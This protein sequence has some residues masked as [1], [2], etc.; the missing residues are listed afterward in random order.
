MANVSKINGYDLKDT[1]AREQ[2]LG[3]NNLVEEKYQANSSK[4][5]NVE[6][7][8][9]NADAETNARIDGLATLEDG[10]TTGDAELIDARTI[11]TINYDNLG[12]AIRTEFSNKGKDIET[13]IG[14]DSPVTSPALQDGYVKYT[15]YTIID[16][17][18][19]GAYQ[20]TG[21]IDIP[22]KT[23]KIYHNFRFQGSAG[24][25]FFDSNKEAISGGNTADEISVIP[26]NAR[27]IMFSDYEL[28]GNHTG[29]NYQM[30]ISF[31]SN[32][33]LKERL[34]NTNFNLGY[35][36]SGTDQVTP[37]LQDGFVDTRNDSIKNESFSNVYKR[38]DYIEIPLGT[39]KIQHNFNCIN[40]CGY[41]F[42]DSDYT[43]I[44]TGNTASLITSIPEDAKYVMFSDYDLS[45]Q[46]TGK[47]I[48]FICEPSLNSLQQQIN[49]IDNPGCD[50]TNLVTY[51][52]SHVA[53]G[54]WQPD[55][56]D[57]FDITNHTNL[58]VSSSTV[59][60]NTDSEVAPFV[61]SDRISAIETAN[62]DTIII[63]GGTN[64]VHLNTPLGTNAQLSLA[65]ASKDKS[66]F[67]GAYSYLIETL[68]TW[69][70][71]L[72]IILC[73]IPQG[74]Y[75]SGHSVSYKDI[76]DAVKEIANYY[77]LPVADIFGKC[78]INKTNLSTY[79]DDSIHYN[80]TGNKRVSKNIIATI[81]DCYI[82][83][84]DSEL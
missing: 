10:S 32:K 44:S 62:P 31:Q 69:K 15:D 83:Y 50:I 68:L 16:N 67:Y 1:G 78:G 54:L 24:Y 64:D 63:I 5:D 30:M 51:G 43:T 13:I 81:K 73:T 2:I 7:S 21:Y 8:L 57:Y 84:T 77:S 29:R 28:G 53:R 4:I 14:Y 42:A 46:H 26:A 49:E 38:T 6:L 61:D 35:I 74:T 12:S 39:S 70:S 60:I 33:V 58:G 72:K 11:G 3:L 19:D 36:M 55:V 20:R 65:L 25:V 75:D 48:T 17:S 79:S 37:V 45:A 18:F 80:A 66:T 59:A 23:N 9:Q 71:T 22:I 34:D 47:T 56:L 41:L 40:N 27:Y 82:K 52:D 76:S